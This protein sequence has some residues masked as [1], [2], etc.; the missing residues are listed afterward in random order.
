MKRA[1]TICSISAIIAQF[2]AARGQVAFLSRIPRGLEPAVPHSRQAIRERPAIRRMC[3]PV[4]GRSSAR[5]ITFSTTSSATR[6]RR[7]DCARASGNP[8]SRTTCGATGAMLY[9]KM[10]D[11]PTLIT[12]PSGTGKELI[13]RAIAG[14]RYVPF[15]PERM[16]FADAPGES[17]PADQ[18]RRAFA[19]A[20]RIG[21]VRAPARIVHRRDR[22]SQRLA[23]SVPAVG[24]GVSRRTGRN[25][26]GDSGEAAA[27]DRDAPLLG[28]GR[29]RA[30]RVSRAN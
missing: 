15:D 27:R 29:Y 30:A 26:S 22:R 24:L 28:G 23:G 3:S 25:G 14:S 10:G 18:H 13:A 4:S 7:P 1:S 20:D 9:R 5:F 16:E 21:A 11:F 12:G 19:D 17:F 2:V 6:C 8:S